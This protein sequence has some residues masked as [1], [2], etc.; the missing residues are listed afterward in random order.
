[1]PQSSAIFAISNAFLLS[2]DHPV[3]IFNVTGI[4]TDS[5]TAERIERTSLVSFSS[6]DPASTLHTFLAGQPMLISII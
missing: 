6:A 3:R 1:M 5:T 4:D 2:R